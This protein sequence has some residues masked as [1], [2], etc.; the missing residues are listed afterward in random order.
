MT[1]QNSTRMLKILTSVHGVLG[2]GTTLQTGSH[3][4]LHIS[5]IGLPL[6]V[7]P[8]LGL[9]NAELKHCHCHVNN[10]DIDGPQLYPELLSQLRRTHICDQEA[11]LSA[12]G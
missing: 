10:G 11:L 4:F 1:K 12:L 3:A 5:S 9:D 2:E 7:Q 6:P 8:V